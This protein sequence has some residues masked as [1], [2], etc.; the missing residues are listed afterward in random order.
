[1]RGFCDKIKAKGFKEDLFSM[2]NCGL[3]T[4]D[5]LMTVNLMER[6]QD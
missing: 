5:F 1:M 3:D 4:I 6:G 2:Q